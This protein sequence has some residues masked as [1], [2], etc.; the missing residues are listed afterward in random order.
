MNSNFFF[1]FVSHQEAYLSSTRI[2]F[3]DSSKWDIKKDAFLPGK[4]QRRTSKYLRHFLS[5]WPDLLTHYHLTSYS[6]LT[7]PDKW[8]I[9]PQCQ[10]YLRSILWYDS[11]IKMQSVQEVERHHKL[12]KQTI[13]WA[14][15]EII[16]IAQRGNTG[17][18]DSKLSC[19][20]RRLGSGD[21]M[22]QMR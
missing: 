21:A 19:V 6:Q 11:Q 17:C 14:A 3:S 5:Y 7:L 18:Y 15:Q 9:C 13:R 22:Q 10:L 4:S 2:P 8:V 20:Q 12:F 16:Q 1:F